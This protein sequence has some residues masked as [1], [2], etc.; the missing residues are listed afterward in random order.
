[1]PGL[2]STPFFPVTLNVYS[3]GRTALSGQLILCFAFGPYDVNAAR[4]QCDLMIL[5]TIACKS[6]RLVSI[7]S[8]VSKIWFSVSRLSRHVT[9]CIPSAVQQ[10]DIVNCRMMGQRYEALT[11]LRLNRPSCQ[12]SLHPLL[13]LSCCP[14][15]PTCTGLPI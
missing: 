13:N 7:E 8:G 10:P 1:M 6:P 12:L 11:S 2:L 4:Q 5:H 14:V 3:Y 15:L 9:C